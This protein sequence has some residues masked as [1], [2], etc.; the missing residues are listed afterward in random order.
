M[1]HSA[2]LLL[3]LHWPLVEKVRPVVASNSWLR[4]GWQTIHR[5]DS[6]KAKPLYPVRQ[7]HP[8]TQGYA[9][10]CGKQCC[11]KDRRDRQ[12]RWIRTVALITFLHATRCSYFVYFFAR[13]HPRD[14]LGFLFLFPP[15]FARHFFTFD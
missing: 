9:V 2:L 13:W 12:L 6:V 1:R 14:I 11:T 5:R 15:R 10:S 7:R 8:A 3:V 4:G